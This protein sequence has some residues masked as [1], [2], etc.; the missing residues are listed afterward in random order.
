[1]A[2]FGSTSPSYLTLMSLDMCNAH[3]CDEYFG[4]LQASVFNLKKIKDALK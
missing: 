2:L 4:A 3:L 1:M